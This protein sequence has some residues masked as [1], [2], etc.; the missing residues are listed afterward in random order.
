MKEPIIDA[1]ISSEKE[2]PP[3]DGHYVVSNHTNN[4]YDI[5]Y[6]FYDGFGFICDKIYRDVKYWAYPVRKEK[7][8]GKQ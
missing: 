1:W 5:G 8:Y 4:P 2:L 7:K 6:C 3:H